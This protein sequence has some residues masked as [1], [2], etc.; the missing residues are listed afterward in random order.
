[1]GRPHGAGSGAAG[2]Q[3]LPVYLSEVD[4]GAARTGRG[5]GDGDLVTVLQERALGPVGQ[6]DG[7]LAAPG[8]LQQ[9]PA[10]FGLGA[11]DRAGGEHVTG[12]QTG[13]VDGHVRK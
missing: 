5:R 3:D 8:Q 2:G 12:T 9:T 1:T 13:P 6:R 11:A 4:G 7:V 10:L